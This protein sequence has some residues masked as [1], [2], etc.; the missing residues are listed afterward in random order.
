MYENLFRHEEFSKNLT[1]IDDE[2]DIEVDNGLYLHVVRRRIVGEHPMDALAFALMS[3]RED[4]RKGHLI[5]PGQ[6]FHNSFT[7]AGDGP[8]EGIAI[9]L[10]QIKEWETPRDRGEL[11][12][13]PLPRLHDLISDK[14][15]DDFFDVEVGRSLVTSDVRGLIID[16]TQLYDHAE[17][18]SDEVHA[19]MLCDEESS[20]LIIELAIQHAIRSRDVLKAA[21]SIDIL[22][23]NDLSAEEHRVALV[24]LRATQIRLIT[25]TIGNALENR[26]W[27]TFLAHD[28]F[29]IRT[30]TRKLSARVDSSL[31]TLLTSI[32][33]IIEAGESE[34][35]AFEIQAS[36][37]KEQIR[38]KRNASLWQRGSTIVGGAALVGL[39]ASLASIGGSTP[40]S[41]YLR[42]AFATVT[43][44]LGI[45]GIALISD[46]LIQYKS[47]SKDRVRVL[48]ASFGVLAIVSVLLLA[49]LA[50][51]NVLKPSGLLFAFTGILGLVGG[52]LL[53]LV[54][55]P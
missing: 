49:G 48:L 18:S 36:S 44:A 42:A 15:V 28:S 29:R 51:S 8:T 21:K 4:R 38:E 33:P 1:D 46:K 52:S 50:W 26:D 30:I 14:S 16:Y 7:S 32:H 10:C 9:V 17:F 2:K 45:G 47:P 39:F 41:P 6:G 27:H 3:V 53:L 24:N 25:R 31:S 5:V 13:D 40:F 54:R 37:R 22:S 19:E 11:E 35:R 34:I 55:K 43:I 20:P 23:R 12:L